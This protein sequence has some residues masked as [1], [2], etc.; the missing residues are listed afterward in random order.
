MRAAFTHEDKNSH[1]ILIGDLA[2]HCAK[3]SEAIAP[4]WKLLGV[5][6]SP[7]TQR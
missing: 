5:I 4:I 1:K 7:H 6:M 2:M 3:E